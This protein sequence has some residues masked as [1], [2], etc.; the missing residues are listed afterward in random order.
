VA[1]TATA[2]VI[3]PIPNGDFALPTLAAGGYHEGAPTSWTYA[4]NGAGSTLYTVDNQGR[5]GVNV[6]T[7]LLNYDAGAQSYLY[8]SNIGAN[9]LGT[10]YTYTLNFDYLGSQG[11]APIN[12]SAWILSN[13]GAT[14]IASRAYSVSGDDTWH[15]AMV[16]GV[17]TAE[18]TGPL[19]I[20]FYTQMTNTNQT[21]IT[22]FANLQ[23]SYT[24]PVPEPGTMAL[25]VTGLFGL[26]CYAWRKRR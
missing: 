11:T 23:L 5:D 17:T 22:K 2:D 12:M 19:G 20:Q 26:V 10:G 8:Q 14:T 7:E 9:V 3:V 24:A 1:S 25:L 18:M 4:T 13:S 16:S 15:H 6:F 21:I